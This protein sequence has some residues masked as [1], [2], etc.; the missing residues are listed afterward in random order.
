M[1]DKLLKHVFLVLAP[2]CHLFIC[3]CLIFLAQYLRLAFLK[4]QYAR[5]LIFLLFMPLILLE[6]AFTKYFECRGELKWK[7]VAG[8]FAR[9]FLWL[10]VYYVFVE[11]PALTK[12]SSGEI[13]FRILLSLP[14]LFYP[15]KYV[16]MANPALSA[17]LT[18]LNAI[19]YLVVTVRLRKWR[20]FSLIILPGI[21]FY[22]L[23][24]VHYHVLFFKTKDN[25][26]AR[27]EGVSILFSP[28]IA[29]KKSAREM[30]KYPRMLWVDEKNNKLYASFGST[31]GVSDNW[32]RES[33]WQVDMNTGKYEIISTGPLF[34]FTKGERERY[35]Y[36]APKTNNT[37]L[38]ISM[39]P[40]K[41]KERLN[42][43]REMLPF[44]PQGI[45]KVGRYVYIAGE[46]SNLIIKYD[47]VDKNVKKVLDLKKAGIARLGEMGSNSLL[48]TADYLITEVGIN[49][50]IAFID[51]E[52]LTLEKVIKLPDYQSG[53][54]SNVGGNGFLFNISFT[55]GNI[56][57]INTK[58]FTSKKL[59]TLPI[60]WCIF[61]DDRN[62]L[63]YSLDYFKGRLLI[64]HSKSGKRRNAFA[65][66][67]KPYALDVT[68]RYIYVLSANGIIRINKDAL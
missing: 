8:L 34:D 59:Y 40:F 38:V 67:D 5:F 12:E 43:G 66:G 47:T 1:L 61:Y 21:S 24:T 56:Y 10:F 60:S 15:I 68:N 39:N 52:N 54:L 27:Q 53:R 45:L 64:V 23:A 26:I 3:L 9:I 19:F 51:P 48:K 31:F 57:R 13:F 22:I 16:L 33:F 62:D 7:D 30:W 32:T 58:N 42:Y 2:A 20:M 37:L 6:V 11:K 55:T 63:L 17:V 46:I 25:E 18:V 49:G 65:V 35:I 4:S 44:A 50:N 14:I 29:K 41:I 28:E 36:A